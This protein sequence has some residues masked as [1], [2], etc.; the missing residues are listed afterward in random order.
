MTRNGRPA[1]ADGVPGRW[2]RMNQPPASTTLRAH[3]SAEALLGRHGVLTRG[4][5]AA[6]GVPGGFAAT[7]RVLAA[8]EDTGRVQRGYFIEGLGAAQFAGSAAVDQLRSDDTPRPVLALAATD[9]ANPYGAALPWPSSPASHLPGR[10]AGATVVIDGDGLAFFVERGGRSLLSW[11][12]ADSDRAEAATVAL[13]S[14]VRSA[15][16]PALHLLKVDGVEI[17]P[18]PWRGP[19]QQAGFLLTPRGLRLRPDR[20]KA[21]R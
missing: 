10:K 11:C 12:L 21:R 1:P 13:V 3:A 19:L 9:P 17:H 7:Y 6:E 4:S 20:A 14:A 18:S 16:R 8:M 5:A 15:H 2:F